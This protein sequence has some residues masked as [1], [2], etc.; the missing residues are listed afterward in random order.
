MRR[1]LRQALWQLSAAFRDLGMADLLRKVWTD[2]HH[3]AVAPLER[4][5][6][7][8]LTAF[9]GSAVVISSFVFEMKTIICEGRTL[10]KER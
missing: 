6:Y 3:F 8:I 2:V 9:A 5:R 1:P 4:N 7:A 10:W